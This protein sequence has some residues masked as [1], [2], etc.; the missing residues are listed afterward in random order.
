MTG[1][2]VG[3]HTQAR[4]VP[5]ALPHNLCFGICLQNNH[6]VQDED[7]RSRIKKQQRTMSSIHVD[8]NVNCH[9]PKPQYPTTFFYFEGAKVVAQSYKQDVLN[10]QISA[11]YFH[12]PSKMVGRIPSSF[13]GN[14][15]MLCIKTFSR[16]P[17]ILNCRC[18]LKLHRCRLGCRSRKIS[19]QLEQ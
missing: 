11:K 3:G 1:C 2:Y 19:C 8:L 12:M 15:S 16:S 5:R 18:C 4:R 9:R 13:N 14:A 17:S 10:M 7:A 6:D